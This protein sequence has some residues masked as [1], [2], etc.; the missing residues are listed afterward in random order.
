[1]QAGRF[2]KILRVI[3]ILNLSLFCGEHA[4][5]FPKE[6]ILIRH[7]DKLNQAKPG[8]FLSPKGEIRSIAFANYYLN[9]FSEP[10]YIIATG[11][12][13]S[14]KGSSMRE[15]Q[16][17]APLANILAERHPQTGFTILRYYRNK[18]SQ[19]LINDLLHDKKYNGKIILICWHHAKIPQLL[20]GLGVAHIQKKLDINNFDTVYVVKYDSS[21]KITQFNLLEQQYTVLFNGS[22]KEFYQKLQ[23]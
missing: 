18:D 22:W 3:L 4:F 1:M 15:I 2:N 21:G 20:K 5:A 10:D 16:T 9:K 17:V 7:A 19:E 8:P 12:T 14:G 23:V 11:P 13:D 6:I